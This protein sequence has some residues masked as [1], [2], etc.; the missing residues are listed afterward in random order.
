M[1]SYSTTMQAVL[2]A[3]QKTIGK[4][5]G[6][7][8]VFSTCI[9]L[10]TARALDSWAA[11][12]E[13]RSSWLG[14][15]EEIKSAGLASAMSAEVARLVTLEMSVESDDERINKA[16][17]NLVSGIRV[18]VEYGCALGGV[19]LKPYLSR[20]GA[21]A[22]QFIR[23][24][25]FFPLSFTSLGNIAECAMI[26]QVFSGNTAY[27]RVEYY[28]L[29]D[30]VIKNRAF[31]VAMAGLDGGLLLDFGVEI[32]LSTVAQWADIAPESTFTGD[33]LPFGYFRF[34]LA[35]T[36]FPDSPLGVSMFSRARG[37][38]CEAD[39]R[40]TSYCWEI[41]AKEAAVH[42]SSSLL[43]RDTNSDKYKMPGGRARLYRTINYNSGAADK[44]F[45]EEY[46]PEIRNESLYA[47]YQ[48]QVRMIEFNCGLA[49][50]TISDPKTT[51][52][53]ATEVR[54]S[55]QRLYATVSDAQKALESA[56]EQY[57]QAVAFLLSTKATPA[58]Y[59]W[60]D[61]IVVDSK[62]LQQSKLL[63]FGAGI[64]DRVQY[65][66]DV[67][68][69]TDDAAIKHVAKMDERAGANLPPDPN[70]GDA[71]KGA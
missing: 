42:V 29:F 65:F 33:A 6:D 22:T 26:E 8:T 7:G 12:Y 43:E 28:S 36:R 24:D 66:I 4:E 3:L 20:S 17:K 58:R 39:R 59:V 62:E 51:D 64:I 46:S 9:N 13:D 37:L 67:Y 54:S 44:P 52:K 34:P 47:A 15:K 2:T 68:G 69:M 1:G 35:N 38:I 70:A 31:S 61:S 14:G 18:P 21:I 25:K 23:A 5:K 57:I 41:E 11:I 56:I 45:M 30:H 71:S 55:K 60:D 49:F 40:Y 50:G 32:A 16:L 53:T 10:E 63:E 27:T 48:D 19:L